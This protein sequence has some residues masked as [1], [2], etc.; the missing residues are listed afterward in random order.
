LELDEIGVGERLFEEE[1]VVNG[2]EVSTIMESSERMGA[3]D[4][5]GNVVC[6]DE[7][8]KA[9][10]CGSPTNSTATIR[11]MPP[12]ANVLRRFT[13]LRHPDLHTRPL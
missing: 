6:G 8:I 7:E 4:S 2:V 1:T 10:S 13:H 5:V 9:V 11:Q 3:G 12:I